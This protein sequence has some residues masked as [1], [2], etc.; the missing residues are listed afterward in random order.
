MLRKRNVA[1]T[2]L[3]LSLIANIPAPVLAATNQI[4]ERSHGGYHVLFIPAIVWAA[5]VFFGGLIALEY[6][7]LAY[8]RRWWPFDGSFG[9]LI[10]SFPLVVF[11]LPPPLAHKRQLVPASWLSLPPRLPRTPLHSVQRGRPQPCAHT[12]PQPPQAGFGPESHT[13]P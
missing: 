2:G 11:H 10:Y 12:P 13:P 1:L 8:Q 6:L 3:T 9:Q 5:F 7:L 4:A